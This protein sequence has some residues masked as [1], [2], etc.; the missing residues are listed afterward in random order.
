MD[1]WKTKSSVGNFSRPHV[2][3]TSYLLLPLVSSIVSN[4]FAQRFLSFPPFFHPFL[5]V[6][7]PMT[8]SLVAV[9]PSRETFRLRYR[10][11]HR[12]R[13]RLSLIQLPFY[14]DFLLS[15]IYGLSAKVCERD[16]VGGCR[17]FCP[18][19]IIPIPCIYFPQESVDERGWLDGCKWFGRDLYKRWTSSR[20]DIHYQDSEC[21]VY[22]C[23][24][25]GFPAGSSINGKLTIFC[26]AIIHRGS[27]HKVGP[28]SVGL[29]AGCTQVTVLP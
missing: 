22:E 23:L 21:L 16:R 29:M 27:Y 9:Y 17:S 5:P 25:T 18:R 10:K 19:W 14:S 20:S 1:R 28:R 8:R 3:E 2:P 15:L 11:F 12:E 4:W 24:P 7:F 6:T 13:D 26:S